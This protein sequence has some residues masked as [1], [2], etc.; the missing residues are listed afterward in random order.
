[1]DR[2]REFLRTVP[3][4]KLVLAEKSGHYV[5]NDEPELVVREVKQV[6]EGVRR[7]VRRP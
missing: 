4:G 2:H 7:K 3:D 6:V 5:Q 1:M